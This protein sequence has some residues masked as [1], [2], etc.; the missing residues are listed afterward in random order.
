MH[1]VLLKPYRLCKG[2]TIGIFTPSTPAN[3]IFREKYLHGI[4]EIERLGFKDLE[5]SL[6]ARCACD[7][8]RSGT[9]QERAREFMELIA[10]PSVKGLISTIGGMNSGSLLPY[11]NFDQIRAARKVICG[12]S[13]VTALHVGI[14]SVSMLTTFYGPAVMPSFGESPNILPDTLS[15][16]LDAVAG[17]A[18]STRRIEPPRMYSRHFRSAANS[19]WKTI[20]REFEPNPGWKVIRKGEVRARAIWANFNTLLTLAGTRYFPDLSGCVLMIED[21]SSPLAQAE[22]SLRQ[23]QLMG[24]LE[25][26]AGLIIG[27]SERT[28]NQGAHFSEEELVLEIVGHGNYPVIIGFDCSHTVPMHT[29]GQGCAISFSALSNY[30][31]H[32]EVESVIENR[33]TSH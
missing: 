16:F 3:M 14:Y 20:P 18:K 17:D 9:P 25:S 29:L 30:L 2:D 7:G 4:T 24:C 10:N 5:G 13:D 22:R 15:S 6:T 27:K 23:L 19:D 32:I 28:D 31:D 21:A 12:Y 8:Y 1:N 33:L 11:L 26:L